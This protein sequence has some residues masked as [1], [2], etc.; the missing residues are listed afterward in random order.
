[1][2][3][4]VVSVPRPHGGTLML[5]RKGLPMEASGYRAETQNNVVVAIEPRAY[6]E[7]IGMALGMLRPH[8]SVK[9]VEGGMLD[10][11][12]SRTN[13]LLVLCDGTAQDSVDGV[14]NR[15]VLSRDV[16]DSSATVYLDGRSSEVE[17]VNME[18]LL[19]IVDRVVPSSQGDTLD[20]DTHDGRKTPES[21]EG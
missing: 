9:A 13:P 15:V 10:A 20:G 4:S 6:R 5:T 1:M 12:H 3:R 18:A 7:V 19:G 14:P 2:S 21:R 16:S 17:K 11:E 8:L